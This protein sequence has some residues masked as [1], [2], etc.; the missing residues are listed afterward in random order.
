MAGL[1]RSKNLSEKGLN[2]KT[3]LQ[4]LYAPGIENDLEL[5]SLSSKIESIV[6]SGP[7]FDSEEDPIS[8][9]YRI[10]SQKIRVR[11]GANFE[12]LDRTRFETKYFTLTNNNEVYF[13]KFEVSLGSGDVVPPEL[14]V[15]GSVPKLNLIYGGRG[16]YFV[17]GESEINQN[18][19][20]VQNVVLVGEESASSTL[21]GAVVFQK[22]PE[23]SPVRYTIKSISITTNGS[24]YFIPENLKI[25]ENSTHQASWAGQ[26]GEAVEVT[27]N[28]QRGA[29]FAFTLPIIKTALKY[30]VVVD[31]DR[32][33]FY[34]FDDE[35]G[36]YLFLDRNLETLTNS[37][38][39]IR[40]KDSIRIENLL[41]F[42]F[43]G[44]RI[45][46]DGYGDPYEIG[47]SISGELSSLGSA[48]TQ[49]VDSSKTII[50][51]TK[52]PTLV[53]DESNTLGFR[54]NEF[55]GRDVLIWQRLILR[56]QDYLLNPE[57]GITGDSLKNDVE[58]FSLELPNNGGTRSI[59]GLFIK[60]GTEYFRAF[61]T[62]DKPFY[63]E[64]SG[65]IENPVVD[66]NSSSFGVLSAESRLNGVK[67]SYNTQIAEFAQRI[68]PSGVDGALYFHKPTTPIVSTIPVK[69]NN[70][71]TSIFAVPLFALS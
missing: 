45:S 30:Y 48:V 12:T 33:G 31:A 29:E 11:V 9:I 26:V 64:N 44:S 8:Q 21:R 49:L 56:D 66:L 22:E 2:L 17:A 57:D 5:F 18:E 19:V 62:T 36:R 69:K 71:N 16:Y 37:D 46:I 47:E 6:I 58:N 42:K 15:G 41:Q 27:L 65:V 43:A 51:N 10:E 25:V 67:Y 14:S 3:S 60:I 68:S 38:L 61:S 63:I 20:T 24:G 4:K 55:V 39:E 40:R 23:S 59:P 52:K 50:Q 70:V 53:T 32:E 1:S 35:S 13:N 54:Y 7:E 34:L 28:K